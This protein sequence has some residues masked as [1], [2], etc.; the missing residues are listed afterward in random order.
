MPRPLCARIIYRTP[1]CRRFVPDTATNAC[2]N[3]TMD[4]LEA[5]RMIDL[6]QLDQAS[7]AQRMHVS[8]STMQ[9]IINRAH[10]KVAEALAYGTILTIEGGSVALGEDKGWGCARDGRTVE[11]GTMK[12]AIP[13]ENGEVFPHFGK[14]EQFA[15]YTVEDKKIVKKEVIG[16]NGQGHGALAGMLSNLEVD[17]VIA[18]GIGGGAVTAL[19]AAGIT[20]YAG[21]QGKCDD[22]AQAL[23]DGTLV[24]NDQPTCGCGHHHEGGCGHHHDEGCGHHEGGCGHHH[25]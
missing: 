2:I 23:L 5:L 20:C 19:H 24:Q 4:E 15:I 16:T 17:V 13:Y 12:I 9:N 14:S 11:E 22:F 3:L 8:R 1:C 18:G 25:C 21:A 6:V 10:Q 7:A